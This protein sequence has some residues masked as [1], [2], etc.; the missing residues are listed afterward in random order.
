MT[1]DFPETPSRT[2]AHAPYRNW[3]ERARWLGICYLFSSPF[4]LYLRLVLLLSCSSLTWGTCGDT[5]CGWM[6][7]SVKWNFSKLCHGNSAFGSKTTSITYAAVFISEWQAGSG[8]C[9]PY[10][11]QNSDLL[12][13]LIPQQWRDAIFQSE[14]VSINFLR[15][16]DQFLECQYNQEDDRRSAVWLRVRYRSRELCKY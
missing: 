1:F 15:S 10:A 16:Q 13:C 8:L 2:S 12:C 3:T 9:I 4:G 7:H 5:V 11:L 14:D 6:V